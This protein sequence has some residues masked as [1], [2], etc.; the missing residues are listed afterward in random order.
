MS[1]P[2]SNPK[3]SPSQVPWSSAQ[4]VF[5]PTVPLRCT[6]PVEHSHRAQV[7]QVV[8]PR[9]AA[10]VPV[11]TPAPSKNPETLTNLVAFLNVFTM[12]SRWSHK[13]WVL[14]QHNKPVLESH[15]PKFIL[16]SPLAYCCRVSTTSM[17]LGPTKLWFPAGVFNTRRK[18][19]YTNVQ[20]LPNSRTLFPDI[21]RYFMLLLKYDEVICP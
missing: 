16:K 17:W 8:A 19:L 11:A 2:K 5:S 12:F 14:N 3:S 21:A 18:E 9:L 7:A 6:A 1:N 4:Q 20:I 13:N 15:G 10:L